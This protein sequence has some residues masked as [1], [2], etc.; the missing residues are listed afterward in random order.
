MRSVK[1][2]TAG[3]ITLLALAGAGAA[4][5]PVGV[6][7]TTVLNGSG[8]ATALTATGPASALTCPGEVIWRPTPRART[9][10]ANRTPPPPPPIPQ[11]PTGRI[12]GWVTG[13]ASGQPLHD[14]MV[15]VMVTA[16][17]ATVVGFALE[18]ATQVLEGRVPGVK[19]VGQLRIRPDFNTESYAHI[20]END[21]RLVS[22]SP[23]S[24]FSIDVDRAS[25]A[26]IRRFI[27]DGQRPPLDA[28]RVEDVKLAEKGKG[29]DPRGYRGEF[30]RLV[31]A[32]RDLRLLT[33]E[34]DGL[35]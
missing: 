20:D 19:S 12:E 2:Q 34:T 24:T 23:L 26:N 14:A 33:R 27:Q 35:R 16:G 25:Y 10:R 3:T 32:T 5:A 11:G 1:L 18:E 17:Q 9:P 21:F 22:A 15:M 29:D 6:D 4:L 30:M 13:A 28:V 8:L 7:T 31:E